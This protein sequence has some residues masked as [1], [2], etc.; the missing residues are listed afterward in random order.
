MLLKVVVLVGIAVYFALHGSW[1]FAVLALAALWPR[2]GIAIAGLLTI[3]LAFAREVWPAV[4]L[5]A[6]ILFN[7][8]GNYYFSRQNADVSK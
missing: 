1:F 2:V 6:L 4:I 8:L 3:L 5:A 7:L